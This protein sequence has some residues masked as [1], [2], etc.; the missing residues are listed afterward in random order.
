MQFIRDCPRGPNIPVYMV[1][2]GTL[3]G[4]RMF[5]TLYSQIRSRRPD[6]L[7]MPS[8][9]SQI[10]FKKLVSVALSCFLVVWFVLGEYYLYFRYSIYFILP[11]LFR[12][13]NHLLCIQYKSTTYL[14]SRKRKI[15]ANIIS[16]S[17]LANP[18]EL[19]L[20]FPRARAAI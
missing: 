15:S 8:S 11:I 7:S 9:R 20:R 16:R 5:W 13:S 3:G 2:G 19:Q 6:V 10:S 12:E 14:K 17:Y 4:I 1:V 18:R